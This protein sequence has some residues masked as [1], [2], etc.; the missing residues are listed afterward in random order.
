MS[1][2]FKNVL[3]IEANNVFLAYSIVSL[4]GPTLGVLFGGITT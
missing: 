2:Y 3:K 4:T 1:D